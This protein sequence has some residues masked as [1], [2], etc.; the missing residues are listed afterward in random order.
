MT[1][2]L[3]GANSIG[4]GW[5]ISAVVRAPS[6]S[7]PDWPMLGAYF[8]ICAITKKRLAAF[9]VGCAN[10]HSRIS[11]AIPSFYPMDF[12]RGPQWGSRCL[13]S[14]IFLSSLNGTMTLVR[15]LPL[16]ST[17]SVSRLM[18]AYLS[19]RESSNISPVPKSGWHTLSPF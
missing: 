15:F 11:E 4:M 12:E 3:Y 19:G 9:G 17:N 16:L 5:P 6:E 2:I 8:P 7:V 1:P 18:S 10:N 13:H 14:S